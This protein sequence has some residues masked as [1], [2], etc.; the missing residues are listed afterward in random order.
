M[1]KLTVKDI[2][3]TGKKVLYRVDYNVPVN[4]QGEITE[5]TRIIESLPTLR[6][7]IDKGAKIIIMAH[8]GRPKGKVVED[9]RLDVVAARLTEVLQQ[10]V[11][12][13]DD[14]IGQ[15][16]EDKVASMQNGEVLLLEN[17]RFH[18]E[19]EANDPDFSAKLAR[20]G[21]LYVSDGFGVCHRAHASTDGVPKLLPLAVAGFLM[22]KEINFLSKAVK[23]P[24]KPFVAV[25]GG[26]KVST[27]I[28]V[29]ENL[30]DEVD[31][32]IIGGGMVY[33]FLAAQ[34]Y[35]IGKSL[36]EAD[37]L[38]IAK[39]I[40]AK[41]KAK[42]VELLLPVDTIVTAKLE[43]GAENHA[44]PIEA[45]PADLMGVDIGP[46][47]VK[48]FCNRLAGAK[49][50]VW[51]GP[52][53]VF[54]MDSF[55]VGTKKIAEAIA[56]MPGTSIVGGGDSVAALEKFKLKEKMTHVS[57]GGGASLEFLEGREL[58]GIAVLADKE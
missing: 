18:A 17:L 35:E 9:L 55:A 8:R 27:K 40:L 47:T 32:L 25:I 4:A 54:E 49:T 38:D 3:V 33:T 46:E 37:K 34:G 39:E 50:V 15:E 24:E 19:E 44:V 29:I 12:K 16:V 13:M 41:A 2:D 11:T 53:G 1:G 56:A 28:A 5:D 22:E 51:N 58:P 48:L 42:G 36:L 57:T 52:M 30:L 7:L 6:Y 21:D 43:D 26:S 20:L 14:C 10:P 31:H 45:I 23:N